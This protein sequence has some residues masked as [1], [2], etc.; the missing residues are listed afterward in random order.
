MEFHLEQWHWW[1]LCLACMVIAAV[2]RGAMTLW[3]AAASGVLGAVTWLTPEV[4]NMYQLMLFLLIALGG[5][6][7]M[8]LFGKQSVGEEEPAV[9][10]E[11]RRAGER[12]IGREVTLDEAIVNGFG[13]VTIDGEFWRVRGE[14]S[15]AGTQM[16][17]R[18]ADGI[19]RDLLIVDRADE[20]EDY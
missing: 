8:D 1:A 10:E 5:A 2:K 6:A 3:F 18:E 17:V 19:D 11:V 7:M 4:P 14:D 15:P 12:F 9:P 13:S 16:I 20:F